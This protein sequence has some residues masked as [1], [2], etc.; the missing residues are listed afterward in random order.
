MDAEDSDSIFILPILQEAFNKL[1]NLRDHLLLQM[2]DEH[3]KDTWS[4]QWGN[5]NILS[6]KFL[7]DVFS[8][9]AST[10]DVFLDVEIQSTPR[11]KF[12]AWLILVDRLN[13]K[14]M[15]RR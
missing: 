5:T 2:F 7:Q 9:L 8:K 13:T 3:D 14:M 15:L 12:F 11:V 4:Y 1:Q 6:K 10:P